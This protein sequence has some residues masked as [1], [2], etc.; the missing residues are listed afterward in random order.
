MI[1][2][3]KNIT[4]TK[5]GFHKVKYNILDEKA[6]ATIKSSVTIVLEETDVLPSNSL[7]NIITKCAEIAQKNYN[8]R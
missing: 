3:F 2:S 4:R 5:E 7:E 8:R 1:V 6:D